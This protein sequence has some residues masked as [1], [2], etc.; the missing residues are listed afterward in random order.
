M[1]GD[2]TYE[3]QSNGKKECVKQKECGCTECCD[4]NCCDELDYFL[5]RTYETQFKDQYDSFEQYYE[6]WFEEFHHWWF[7]GENP[8]PKTE[9]LANQ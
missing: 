3:L 2:F 5:H 8:P 7:T 1:E 9:E 6:D 4:F